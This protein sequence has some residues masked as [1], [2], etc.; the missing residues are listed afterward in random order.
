MKRRGRVDNEQWVV[1]RDD[2]RGFLRKFDVFS[3]AKGRLGRL[4]CKIIKLGESHARKEEE[5]G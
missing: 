3:V 2:L 5:P 4:Y 1:T